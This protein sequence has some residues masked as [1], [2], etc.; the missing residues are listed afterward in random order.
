MTEVIDDASTLWELLE[1]RAD[2]SP[3]A[4]MLIDE[5]DRTVSFGEFKAWSERVAAGLLGLGI[6]PDT[7]VAWQLPTRIESIVLS[8]ALARL[9]TTQLPLIPIYREREVGSVIVQGRRALLRGAG[10]VAQLR[11]RG[12]GEGPPGVDRRA[13]RDP[14]RHRLAARR[15]TRPRCRRPRPT[16]TRCAG[17][18]RRRAPPQ[19]PSA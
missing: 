10:H 18:T 6:T 13:V 2:R 9:G 11:L 7:P 14:A 19:R 3:D 8:F 17:S 15:A 4:P 12:D 16:A 1:R 5:Q